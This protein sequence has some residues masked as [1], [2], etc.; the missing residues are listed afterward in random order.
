[1]QQLPGIDPRPSSFL[2][3]LDDEDGLQWTAYSGYIQRKQELYESYG[4][5]MEMYLLAASEDSNEE[6]DYSRPKKRTKHQAILEY[7]DE[8]GIRKELPPTKTPWYLMYVDIDASM[9]S[10]RWAKQFRRRFRVPHAEYKEMV[11]KVRASS[12][13]F[14]RWLK[15]SSS[16]I[17]LLVLGSFRYL[18]RGLTFDDLE[19]CTGISEEVHRCFFHAFLEFGSTK[20]FKEYVISPNESNQDA[21]T[22][23]HEY[24]TAGCNGAIGSGDAVHIMSERISYKRKNQNTGFKMSHTARTYNVTVNHRRRILSTTSGHPATWNDKL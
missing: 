2:Q 1:M 11:A 20:L 14:G 3:C 17:D 12:D 15:K 5:E 4:Q 8:N 21:A 9:Q 16:S 6:T 13:I 18:G 23:Q 10:N 24:N 19:E 7:T 22:H